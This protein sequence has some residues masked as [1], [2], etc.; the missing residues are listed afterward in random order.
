MQILNEG[1]W[2]PPGPGRYQPE[3]YKDKAPAFTIGSKHKH[4]EIPAHP[5]GP[6]QYSIPNT[7]GHHNL[8]SNIKNGP[9]FTLGCKNVKT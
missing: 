1:L 4:L 8:T 7:I 6:N 5:V 3:N 2:H 9:K